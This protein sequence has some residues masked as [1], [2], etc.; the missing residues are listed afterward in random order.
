MYK[1]TCIYTIHTYL[2]S[3]TCKSLSEVLFFV[4]KQVDLFLH[5]W[6]LKGAKTKLCT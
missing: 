4:A 6:V 5:V 3:F 2:D 1:Y